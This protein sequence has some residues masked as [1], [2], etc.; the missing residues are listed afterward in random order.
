[1]TKELPEG[2][3]GLAEQL[4]AIVNQPRYQPV[5]P[6]V[7]AKKL[8]LGKDEHDTVKKAVKRLVKQGK[9]SYGAKHCVKPAAV[10]ETR[11][12]KPALTGTF[13]RTSSGNG[14]VSPRGSKPG[15]KRNDIYIPA[16]KCRDASDGD[17]VA[18]RLK[19][20][21]GPG[22]DRL[23]GEVVEILERESH[24]FVG[25]Y[26][27]SGGNGWVQV[28]GK[29]FAKPILV[30]DPGAK[31]AASGDKVVVEMVRFPSPFHE[32]EGVI[33]EVLGP[34]GQPGVDTLS[35]IRE[36]DLPGDFPEEVQSQARELADRFEEVVPEG[37]R[38]FTGQAVVTIDPVDARDFDDA[39][40]LAKLDNGHWTLAVHIAD[41][42]HFVPVGTPLDDEARN[43]ATSVYL[44]DR[45]IPMLPET[46]SNHL[47]SLQP[48]R[49]RLTRT[50][51]MEFDED[52]IFIGC[53]VHNSV[54]RSSRR[55]AYE[56]VDS[57]LADREAWRD[58]LDP[59][60]FEL[61]SRMH[62]LAMML[63]R[64][65][66]ER[67]AIE[68][69]LPEVKIDLNKLGEVK[70][71]HLV[72]NTE[73]HQIIEEFMLAANQAVA[74]ILHEKEIACLRRI[75]VRPD[76]RKLK[77]LTEFVRELGIPCETL[78][79][80]F[81]I[82][83]I[84][85]EVAGKPQERAVNF[86]VLKSMQKAVYSPEPEIHYALHCEH[87]CHFTSPIRRYPDLVI[88]RLVDALVRNQRP[89]SNFDAMLLLG[90]H[91]SEREQRAEKAERELNK[92]KLLTLLSKHIGK[93]FDA[94]LT[95]VE[96]FG[97][98]AQGVELPAE[99]L[100]H[101]NSL[102]DDYYNYDQRTHSLTGYRE[103]NSYRLGDTVRVEVSHVDVDRRELDFRLMARKRTSAKPK[104]PPQTDAPQT[105]GPQTGRPQTGRPR[106]RVSKPKAARPAKKNR[107]RS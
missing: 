94:V 32:G 39:I 55:F 64:R 8:G 48:E 27:E 103:G 4:L 102:T 5:K 96:R 61:L 89:A 35:I 76:P 22:D 9:L 49:L 80:R 81:E 21:G 98:F 59:A 47:A 57:Y 100:I 42:A 68:L 43:R 99:G 45:V 84:I 73:S 50:A 41:V 23:R 107:R 77:A 101:V 7:L 40:S 56:E 74:R 95:G 15:D 86:A 3:D 11:K 28:D 25:V 29:V 104:R 13:R 44:P 69:T 72:E 92:V 70:G 65:R 51:E 87:Y 33:V 16:D 10:V 97:L 34:R 1:M 2:A 37:R 91:C 88:H 85:A 60:V 46:I 78:E 54:I 18:V 106:S 30:G 36:F 75:H 52:G 19:K 53:E 12:P 62:E 24:R 93:Q 67:G 66:L 20:R 6:R 82:K 71:A 14:F 105:D 26:S 31:N 58:K 63:R 38:D 90:E 79:S 17:L 83:R